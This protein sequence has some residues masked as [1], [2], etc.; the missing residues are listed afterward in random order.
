MIH[1]ECYVTNYK[2]VLMKDN[3]IKT[4]RES[5]HPMFFQVLKDIEDMHRSKGSDYGEDEDIFANIRQASDWGIPSWIGAMIRAGD[6]VAR[7]K[8]ASTG[9]EL[10]NESVEDSFMDLACYSIIGLIL[11]REEY[12]DERS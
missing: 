10:R 1:S 12:A 3:D 2:G 11:Y 9:R 5:G 4:E 7:L 6:K 8:A